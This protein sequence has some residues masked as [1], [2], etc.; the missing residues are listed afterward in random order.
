MNT[1]ETDELLREALDIVKAFIPFASNYKAP[2][3]FRVLDLKERIELRLNKN[4][5]EAMKH[6]AR[7]NI[8]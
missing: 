1:N 6:E 8:S 4:F 2:D 7:T 5:H 3:Y